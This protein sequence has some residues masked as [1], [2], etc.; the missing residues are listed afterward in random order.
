MNFSG[1]PAP[2]FAW[3]DASHYAWPRPAAG[4]QG[5]VDWMKVEAATD[6]SV[7]LFDAAKATAA[8]ASLPG[9]AAADA[10]RVLRSP[11]LVFNG[12]YT[13]AIVTLG[14]DLYLCDFGRQSRIPAHHRHGRRGRTDVQP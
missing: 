14:D 9:V 4:D 2:A 5:L 7:T 1:E 6:S 8:L 11:D 10:Q 13:K 12:G 3:I